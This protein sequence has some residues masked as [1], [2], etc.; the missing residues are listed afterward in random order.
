MSMAA[1]APRPIIP[2]VIPMAF[3]FIIFLRNIIA[4]LPL[5]RNLTQY[6]NFQMPDTLF[7]FAQDKIRHSDNSIDIEG[8]ESYN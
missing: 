1:A 8:M 4:S 2:A 5:C 3:D 7:S 6:Y